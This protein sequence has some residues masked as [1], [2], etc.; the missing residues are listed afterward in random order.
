MSAVGAGRPLAR[1]SAGRGHG[2]RD[3]ALLVRV[4][5]AERRDARRGWRRPCARS[6]RT[7]ALAGRLASHGRARD[8]PARRGGPRDREPEA[9]SPRRSRPRSGRARCL[10]RKSLP[11]LP[12]PELR[13]VLL[14]AK[15]LG[16][17]S[18]AAQRGSKLLARIDGLRALI[19]QKAY[20]LPHE[21]EPAAGEAS[22]PARGA[23]PSSG[24]SATRSR[25]G[26]GKGSSLAGEG[27]PPARG[28]ALA[29]PAGH[30]RPTPSS[31]PSSP[32]SRSAPST[33]TLEALR[34]AIL[35]SL[36]AKALEAAR[37]RAPSAARCRA[38]SCRR[39]CRR[40]PTTA[41]PPR[42]APPRARPSGSRAVRRMP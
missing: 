4:A 15:G 17:E 27:G 13:D 33:P 3:V 22:R 32:P 34:A 25:P 31:S 23:S 12:W 10:G 39:A 1:T 42:H 11:A 18:E 2:G 16:L 30:S 19:V 7:S 41:A 8:R 40:P 36:G 6:S 9:V 26:L 28:P 14:V 24:P 20:G 21:E 35:R 37:R 5:A 29:K 38:G